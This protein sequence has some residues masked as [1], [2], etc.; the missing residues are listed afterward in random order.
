MASRDYD[1]LLESFMNNSAKVYNEDKENLSSEE[2]KVPSSYNLDKTSKKDSKSVKRGRIIEKRKNK[3][4]ASKKGVFKRQSAGFKILRVLI[5]IF[6]VCVVVGVVCVSV[7]AIYAYSFVHG[8]AVFNLTE[9]KYAQ[10]QTSFIYYYDKDGNEQELTRLHGDENRVWVNLDEMSEYLDDAFIA[11]EDKRFKNHHGVDWIRTTGVIVK[12]KNLGQGG[13]TITQQLIKNLTDENQVTFARKFNEI[14]SALNLERYYEKEEIVEVYLNTIYLSHGCYGVKTA[15]EQ[16]FGKDVSDLNIAECAC[17][18]GITQFPTRYDPLINPE[19]N[20]ERQLTVLASMLAEGFITQEQYDEAV[21]YEMV[22]TNSENYKGSQVS[23]SS[24]ESKNNAIDSWFIDYVI[25]TALDDLEKQGYTARKAK[26]LL[27]GGGLKIYTTMDLDVQQSLE[28]VYVNYKK[29]PDETVQGAMVIMDYNG[30]VLGLI[31][32]TGKKEGA[33]NFNR[34]TDAK[35]QPGSTIKPL[36]VYGPAFEKSLTDDN[37]NLYW[38]TP[39]PDKPTDIKVDGK[40]W[41][42]NE[43]NTF[44]G[45]NVSVQYGLSKS[46]NTISAHTL[47]KIGVDYSYNFITDR[48]HIS[49]LVAQDCDYSPMATGSLTHGVSVLEMT[50]AYAAFGNGGQYYYPYCYYK[51]TD[52]QGNVILEADPEATKERALSESTGW[53]MNKLLQT[54]M[55]SGTGTTYKLSGVECFGKTG[56]TTGSVDRWFVGG[57]PEYVAAVW[58]GYDAQ[59]EIVYRLSPNPSGTLWKTVLTEVYDRK[60]VNT[61]TFPE[62]DG[63]VRKAY[64]PSNGLLARYASGNYGWYDV[65]N[66]PSYSASTGTTTE[67]TSEAADTGSSADTTVGTSSNT[68]LPANA[69]N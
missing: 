33:L 5:G 49:S 36:S 1:D 52:S 43:G 34:A 69:N 22:F 37:F 55:T 29:M 11:I 50:A 17:L 18:A 9:Q 4:G 30:K 31:G 12:P 26:S 24:S 32:G 63:I 14:L 67:Y 58:Y 40:P 27:Y 16:Y 54:T 7:M 39:T 57:T 2:N 3:Q 66:L 65:N 59:K 46:L 41:P 44:S 60:G 20:R 48:F 8:D 13:S 45:N 62:Y 23:N 28:D 64:D 56:T 53:L 47:L 42:T 61:K 19:N 25:T 51:I 21:A 6:M 15:A 10:N 35:R 68:H 38:S